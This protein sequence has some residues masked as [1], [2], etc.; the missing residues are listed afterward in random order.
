MAHHDLGAK[1]SQVVFAAVNVNQYHRTV[2]DMAAY[3]REQALN[4]IPDWHF[5]TG[6]V[7]ALQSV[8]RGYHIEVQVPNPNAD[9]VH[10]SAIYF[11]DP[12]GRERYL[13]MPEVDHTKSGTAYLP[14][15]Q[16][17]SWGHGIA[18]LAAGL[19]G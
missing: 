19:V 3:S 5:F 10:T 11:I 4:T 9:I 1:A 16:Q 8:W 14:A 18:R 2:A 6:P 17:A 7:P 13:A 15:D 12:H